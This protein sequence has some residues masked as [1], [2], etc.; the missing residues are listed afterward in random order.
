MELLHE[1]IGKLWVQTRRAG[2]EEGTVGCMFNWKK[3]S[4]WIIPNLSE[5]HNGR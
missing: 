4:E 2:T 5:P 1:Q 3:M